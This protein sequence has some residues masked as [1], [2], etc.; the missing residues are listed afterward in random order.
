MKECLT[1]YEYDWSM[2]IEN[3]V[4]VGV[5]SSTTAAYGYTG[6]FPCSVPSECLV[7]YNGYNE[8]CEDSHKSDE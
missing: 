5:C 4:V 7:T 8:L 6:A 3:N 2:K 1:W